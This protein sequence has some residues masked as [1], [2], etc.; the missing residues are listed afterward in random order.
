[1]TGFLLWPLGAFEQNGPQLCR[2]TALFVA[3]PM[4]SLVRRCAAEQPCSSLCRRTALFVAVP[5]N[6]LV[7]RCA[8]TTTN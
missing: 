7:R 2:R 5:P 6:S 1:M 4:N 8:I 3:V